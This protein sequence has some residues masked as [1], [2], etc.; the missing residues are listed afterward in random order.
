MLRVFAHPQ[1]TRQFARS[2]HNLP[3]HRP[4]HPP[5]PNLLYRPAVLSV[6][7]LPYQRGRWNS[8]APR[9]AP[10]VGQIAGFHSTRRNEALPVVPLFAAI[11]KVRVPRT[12]AFARV[13]IWRTQ[14]STSIE[15]ARTAGRIALSLAPLLLFKNRKS[16]KWLQKDLPGMEEKRPAILQKIRTRTILFHLLILTPVL[17]FLATI[18]A[19]LERTPVTGRYVPSLVRYARQ[20]Y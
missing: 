19:S 10:W 8:V 17:L 4:G 13:L 12:E 2:F 14:A 7:R 9:H 11:L 15:L 6:T 16:R 1:T 18:V 3:L 20:D 5:W